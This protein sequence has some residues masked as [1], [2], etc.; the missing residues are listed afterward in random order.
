MFV[1]HIDDIEKK[2]LT[3][4]AIKGVTKQ[5]LIG[6]KEGWEDYVMRRFSLEKGGYAPYHAH[7]WPH[8]TYVLEGEGILHLDGVD[9]PISTGSVSYV[10]SDKIHQIKATPT[11]HLVFICIVPPRGDV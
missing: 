7:P 8:I 10:P 4:D 2:I 11:S 5:V 3:S 6:P 1:S 9:Y